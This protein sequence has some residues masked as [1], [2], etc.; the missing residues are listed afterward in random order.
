M[1]EAW[2]TVGKVSLDD[3]DLP[4]NID[5]IIG[6]EGRP[7]PASGFYCVYNEG[8]LVQS[9]ADLRPSSKKLG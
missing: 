1:D 4:S 7:D 5:K 8:R 3:M 9:D 6:F 2:K